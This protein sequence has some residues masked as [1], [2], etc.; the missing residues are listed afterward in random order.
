MPR[1][2]RTDL[3]SAALVVPFLT[4]SVGALQARADAPLDCGEAAIA[5]AAWDLRALAP[6]DHEAR[7]RS[8]V[9]N[10]ARSPA[11]HLALGEAQERLGQLEPAS[12]SYRTALAL[13]AGDPQPLIGLARVARAEGDAEGAE[14]YLQSA[15]VLAESPE[16]Q[17]VIEAQFAPQTVRETDGAT[18]FAFKSDE[19]I[20]SQLQIGSKSVRPKALAGKPTDENFVG[21]KG[22]GINLTVLFDVDSDKLLPLSTSQLDQLAKALRRASSGERY[23]IEGHSSSEGSQPHNVA[24]S[25]ARAAAVLAFLQKAK[26]SVALEPTGRGSE[27]P[28]LNRGVENREKSRRV[29]ILRPYD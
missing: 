9:L 1:F 10:C 17:K 21:A 8:L 18:Q 2:S 12:L 28:V 11:A 22:F 24:L 6:T 26:V 15:L 3:T 13:R 29:T 20:T 27:V 14:I 25:R 4:L 23:I 5:A 19:E 7:A 16:D